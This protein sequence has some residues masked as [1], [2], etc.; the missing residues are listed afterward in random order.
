MTANQMA[1]YIIKRGRTTQRAFRGLSSPNPVISAR[2]N[3]DTSINNCLS[4]PK[5]SNLEVIKAPLE[6]RSKHG[7][8][9]VVR[10]IEAVEAR[11]SQWER[12]RSANASDLHHSIL[13]GHYTRRRHQAQKTLTGGVVPVPEKRAKV[14]FG[15]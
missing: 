15:S 7:C 10:E 1:R 11:V 13:R 9:V 4:L 14:V 3:R 5:S 12:A 8:V 2:A 6:L